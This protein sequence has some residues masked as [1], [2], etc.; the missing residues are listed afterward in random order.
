M[1]SP[2][3]LGLRP[4]PGTPQWTLTLEGGSRHDS[5]MVWIIVHDI[6]MGCTVME[7]S[8]VDY[9]SPT[10]FCWWPFSDGAGEHAKHGA[11]FLYSPCLL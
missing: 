10:V 4:L 6:G 11:F 9:A 7:Y 3:F 1:R 2:M 8:L 5:S